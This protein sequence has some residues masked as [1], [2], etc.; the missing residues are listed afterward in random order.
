MSLNVYAK[1]NKRAY[2]RANAFIFMLGYHIV[3]EMKD[4][5]WKIFKDKV[6]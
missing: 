4:M 5:I 3:W 6:F 1:R 2:K